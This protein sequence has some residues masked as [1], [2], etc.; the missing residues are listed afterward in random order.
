MH[1]KEKNILSYCMS[2]LSKIDNVVVYKPSANRVSTF[3][4]NINGMSSSNVVS[5][6]GRHDICVRGGIHCAILAHEQ[7]G[8]VSTGA[9]RVSLNYL[10][11]KEEVDEF[12]KVIGEMTKCI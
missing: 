12:I 6:L 1:L 7:L 2:E 3:C 4:F 11:T 9:V 5:E 10:N 8:T